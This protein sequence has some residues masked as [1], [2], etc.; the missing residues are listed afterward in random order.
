MNDKYVRR[1]GIERTPVVLISFLLGKKS[2]VN[3]PKIFVQNA[4]AER[5]SE[6]QNNRTK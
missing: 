1:L 6:I 4:P 2:I 5:L 3:K